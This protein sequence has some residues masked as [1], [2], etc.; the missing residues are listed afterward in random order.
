MVQESQQYSV[1]PSIPDQHPSRW[2]QWVIMYPA[3]FLSLVGNMQHMPNLVTA[4]QQGVPPNVAQEM[5]K[6]SNLWKKNI[7]CLGQQRSVSKS[8]SDELVISVTLCPTG[9][10]LVS[11]DDAYP[12]NIKSVKLVRHW[13]E[14]SAQ[15]ENPFSNILMPRAIAATLS[16]LS[17]PRY[18]LNTPT[19]LARVT[20][21][22]Q[23]NLGEGRILRR[24]RHEDGKCFDEVV[25]TFTG[26][27][28]SQTAVSQCSADCSGE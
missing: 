11:I 15:S 5:R 9:D 24:L 26:E 27:V 23:K 3:F 19:K 18:Q 21:I 28:I 7:E 6:Q 8:Q 17:Q 16:N 14:F 12:Q 25:N 10:M 2:W 20:I 4:L 1:I 22:C 13:V